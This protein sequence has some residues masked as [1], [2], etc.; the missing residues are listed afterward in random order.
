MGKRSNNTVCAPQHDGKS[1]TCY[2]EETLSQIAEAIDRSRV[3]GNT[4]LELGGRIMDSPWPG[5]G[6]SAPAPPARKTKR[7][8]W[9]L[10]NR[11]FFDLC[12][13][14]ET[15]WLDA[16]EI[17]GT[18]AA[19]AAESEL[20]PRMPD[21]WS[22]DMHTWLT[23]LDIEKVMRQYER[24]YKTF[25]F[26]GV[27]PMDFASPRDYGD[28]C[29]S[30]AMCQVNVEALL[31]AGITQIGAV[32]NLDNHNQSGSHW[33][34]LFADF[35]RAAPRGRFGVFYYDSNAVEPPKE[36]VAFQNKLAEQVK[37]LRMGG[38]DFAAHHN[39]RRHQFGNSECGIFSMHFIEQM[40][41]G[42]T[43]KMIMNA[44]AYDKAMNKLRSVYYRP[45][46][47]AKPQS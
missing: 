16:P 43:F 5:K 45:P 41:K 6:R 29:V 13:G 40:L 2:S 10:I 7:A 15:C 17:R 20:R 19:A 22:K 31:A 14:D 30:D 39:T 21:E 34:G 23:N 8:L 47:K 24:K 37:A 32:L 42:S 18:R 9:K 3:I 11:H 25:K 27:F 38:R 44:K 4:E 46:T 33:V 35:N 26:M 36:V 12:K 1:A 28:G